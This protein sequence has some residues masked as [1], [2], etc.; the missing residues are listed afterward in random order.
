[1]D[2][3]MTLS[4]SELGWRRRPACYAGLV[5]W[6]WG[7]SGFAG[8]SLVLAQSPGVR[9]ATVMIATS[10]VG[11]CV[12]LW[13]GGSDTDR[14]PLPLRDRWLAAA[15]LV[16]VAGAFGTFSTLYRPLLPDAPWP[17]VGL[18]LAVAIPAYALG[19]IP[20]LLLVW[21]DR[22]VP[23]DAGELSPANIPGTLT[24]ALLSGGALGVVIA[25]AVVLP[26]WNP[27]TLLMVAALSLLIP[28]AVP[29]PGTSIS[30]ESLIFEAVTPIGT[31]R[32][33]DVAFPG[34]RQPERRLY[35]NDEE[36]SGQLVRSGA[37]TL[38]YIAAAEQWLAF[39]T[40]PGAEYL[41][42][43]GGAYTLPRRIAERD[44]NARI[45]VVEIDPEAQRIAHRYFGL[46]PHHRIQSIF[47]DARAFVES[48]ESDRFD[49]VYVDVYAGLELM[50]FSLLTREAAQLI[51]RALRPDGMVGINLIGTTVGDVNRQI[52]SIVR[53]YA[54]VFPEIALYTHLG[55]DYPDRQNLLLVAAEHS[56]RTLPP[57]AGTFDIWPRDEWPTVEGV[58]V[59]RDL[60]IP[61]ESA[62]E[63]ASRR[64]PAA[65]RAAGAREGESR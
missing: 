36:E 30:T 29:A 25:G 31:W 32:V 27:S 20:P 8:G 24:I 22:L 63:A 5:G 50:P 13:A 33:T 57:V 21:T 51:R 60:T 12:G 9:D 26:A 19:L 6:A 35:L 17:V 18:I 42:L 58:I 40:P 16:A 46:A 2:P 34:E 48:V 61:P 47:G 4:A 53:T 41:F 11:F 54:E 39:S 52:W 1:M 65:T 62:S 14:N 7:V 10:V 43:G 45:V 56:R 59:F 64:A 23:E 28:L 49:R 55:R 3:R 37:P 15:A 44:G 38:A